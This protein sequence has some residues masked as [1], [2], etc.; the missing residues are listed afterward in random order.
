MAKRTASSPDTIRLFLDDLE[1]Y[2]LPGPEE[3]IELAK[4]VAAGDEE[5][6]RRMIAA[7]L[8]LVIH[9]ARRYQDRG[10]DFADLLQEGTF[11]LMRA[12]DKFDWERGFRFSTYATWWIRQALQR[13]VQQHGNTIRVPMEV[14][15][16]AQRI[17]RATW[18]LANEL[19]RDP[20][21]AEVA[22]AAGVDEETV[23][24]LGQ[25]ARV[26]ASLDQPAGADST[27]PL[28]DLVGAEDASF[29]DEVERELV[30]ERV[31]AAVDRLGEL[32]R[33]VVRLRFGLDT[34]SPASLQ[35]TAAQLG[36]GVRRA[37]Q[38]EARAL[39]QLALQPEVVAAH[40][41]A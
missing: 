35:A 40:E 10:V 41:A 20:S 29:E 30:M 1:R 3:Q 31:R 26:T 4:A 14:A 6:R 39:E 36:I 17:D 11:G 22:E 16:L 21:R 12:V 37:R 13:A 9:W 7:N 34:G 25:A 24:Q 19:R 23:D 28:G 5:A 8:R 18:E 32:E 33:A 38:A 2:P 15:E 27:T